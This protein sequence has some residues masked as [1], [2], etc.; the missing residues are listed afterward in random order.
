[1]LF[2]RYGPHHNPNRALIE[3]TPDLTRDRVWVVYDR[4]EDNLRLLRAAPERTPYLFDEGA[5]ALYRLVP[6]QGE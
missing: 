5:W 3:N 6:R 1:M 2:V 4:A